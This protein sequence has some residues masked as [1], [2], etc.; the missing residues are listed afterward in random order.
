MTNICLEKSCCAQSTFKP[1]LVSQNVLSWG[2]RFAY[3]FTGSEKLWVTRKLIKIRIE[4][5]R[6]PENLGR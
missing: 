3:I 4:Q 1:R 6:S 5:E 2:H